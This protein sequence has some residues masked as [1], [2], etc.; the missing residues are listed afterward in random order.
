MIDTNNNESEFYAQDD[1]LI[2]LVNSAR[3]RS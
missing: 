2:E 1:Y 3:S